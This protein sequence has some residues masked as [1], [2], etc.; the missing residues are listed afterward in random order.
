[1]A[2]AYRFRVICWRCFWASPEPHY[3]LGETFI[4][5]MSDLNV[6]Q[7]LRRVEGAWCYSGENMTGELPVLFRQ[8]QLGVFYDL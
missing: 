6:G 1:M 2:P 7:Y 5:Q 8:E 3:V 4:Q